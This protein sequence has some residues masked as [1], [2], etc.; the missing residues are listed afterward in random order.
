MLQQT[1]KGKLALNRTPNMMGGGPRNKE[2]TKKSEKKRV[3]K[4]GWRRVEG[5]S[6]K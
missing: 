6:K 5:S 3:K 1:R 2:A 4:K